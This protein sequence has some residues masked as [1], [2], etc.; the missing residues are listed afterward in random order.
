MRTT[1]RSSPS[2][3]CLG[4]RPPIPTRC[5]GIEEGYALTRD[6]RTAVSPARRLIVAGRQDAVVGYRDAER[7]ADRL[8]QATFAVLDGAGHHA[9]VEREHVV[10]ALLGDWLERVSRTL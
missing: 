4:C 7:F 10:D 8:P 1:G 6:R 5:A 3:C 9:H 2:R